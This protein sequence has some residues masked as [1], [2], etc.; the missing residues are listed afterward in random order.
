MHGVI[1]VLQL[2]FGQS[3]F[4]SFLV[5][6]G[7]CKLFQLQCRLVFGM[8]LNRHGPFG[9]GHDTEILTLAGAIAYGLGHLIHFIGYF[10]NQDDVGASGDP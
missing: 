10:R 1:F 7:S 9:D 2:K 5:L 8:I 6:A 3:G 4:R